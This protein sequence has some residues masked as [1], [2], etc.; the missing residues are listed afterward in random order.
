MVEEII[1]LFTVLT[2]LPEAPLQVLRLV[3]LPQAARAE[4]AVRRFE[5]NIHGEKEEVIHDPKGKP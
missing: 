1:R 5:V 4:V 2:Q 3:T